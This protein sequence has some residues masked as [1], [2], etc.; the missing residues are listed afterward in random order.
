MIQCWVATW[1]YFNVELCPIF[2]Y[3]RGIVINEGV[4]IQNRA[5][6]SIAKEDHDKVKKDN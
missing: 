6:N 5:Q 2:I 1:S 3:T 4:K